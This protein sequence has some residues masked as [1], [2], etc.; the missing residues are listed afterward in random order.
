MGLSDPESDADEESIFSK[1]VRVK[2]FL[3]KKSSLV[4][5]HLFIDASGQKHFNKKVTQ[6]SMRTYFA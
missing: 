2:E 5:E 4:K 6:K 1:N 3:K